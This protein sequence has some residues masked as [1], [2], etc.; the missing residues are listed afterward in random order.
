MCVCLE[1]EMAIHSSTIAWKIPWTEEPGR[2]KAHRVAK[3]RTQLS[4]FTFTF[5]FQEDFP[6]GAS[7]KDPA[8]QF[9]R[10]RDSGL[11][12][13]SGLIPGHCN[14]LWYSCLENLM[15]RGV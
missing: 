11:V 12:P 4:D 10:L 14:P 2:L 7:G 15:H 8:C 6:G 3:S 9:W 1:K 5:T 13:G